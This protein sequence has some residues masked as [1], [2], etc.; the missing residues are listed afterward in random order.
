MKLF[1]M[2]VTTQK[3]MDGVNES[4]ESLRLRVVS[5]RHEIHN[6]RNENISR[7]EVTSLLYAEIKQL[8]KELEELRSKHAILVA[9][10]IGDKEAE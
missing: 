5:Q 6:L 3:A 10:V 7:L 9:S 8:K 1:G 2:V 4:N